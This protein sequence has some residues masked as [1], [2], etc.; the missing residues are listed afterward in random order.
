MLEGTEFDSTGVFVATFN[1][2]GMFEL[3]TNL[4]EW[5]SFAVVEIMAVFHF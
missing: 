2:I 5:A 1:I 3:A 4:F